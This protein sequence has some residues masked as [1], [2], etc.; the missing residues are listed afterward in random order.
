MPRPVPEFN[1]FIGQK[2]IVDFLQRQ[3]AGAQARGEPFPPTMITG[4]P[5]LGK[6][7]LARALA[8]AYGTTLHYVTGDI[9]KE[10]LAKLLASVN[11]ND[12]I[13][14]DEAHNFGAA[15]QELFRRAMD[16][17][18]VR[19]PN[20]EKKDQEKKTEKSEEEIP[21]EVDVP[22]KACSIILATDQPS[23]LRKALRSR[24]GHT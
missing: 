14:G 15:Q 2:K 7:Q 4:R 23:K 12:F 19:I 24:M 10:E 13:F 11:E 20:A 18:L 3:L 21:A 8:K 6:T 1:E 22:V 17:R 16:D 9:S 5:G